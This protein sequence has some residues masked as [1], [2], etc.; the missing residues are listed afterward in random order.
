[1]DKKWRK[2]D[3]QLFKVLYNRIDEEKYVPEEW[4]DITIKSVRKNG[5]EKINENQRGLFPM[6]IFAKVYEKVKKAE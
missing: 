1:M 2:R 4:G 6:N 5:K 3:E